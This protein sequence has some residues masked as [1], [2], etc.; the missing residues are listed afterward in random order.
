MY[1]LTAVPSIESPANAAI[2][3]GEGDTQL[4][5]YYGSKQADSY[6]AESTPRTK[7]PFVG[8]W[9]YRSVRSNPDLSAP[10]NELLFGAGR[11]Q[12]RVTAG[13]GQMM[14]ATPFVGPWKQA[15]AESLLTGESFSQGYPIEGSDDDANQL[16][17]RYF[18]PVVVF[19]DALAFSTADMFAAGF[20]DHR[21]GKVICI[22]KNPPVR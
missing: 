20:I 12:F 22:D 7:S 17:Q 10:V 6:S 14:S 15:I 1:A 16:G 21:I 2:N 18:G 8:K 5:Y 19:T 9:S 11:F 3:N 4:F 13:T